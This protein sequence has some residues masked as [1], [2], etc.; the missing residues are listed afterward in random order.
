MATRKFDR[1]ME[2]L[3][4]L[5][6][7]APDADSLR[8]YLRHK[9]NFLV[10]KAAKIAA[11]QGLNSLIPDMLQA[12]PRFVAD[13]AKSDPQ[14]WAKLALVNALAELGHDDSV[15]YL[16]GLAHI[17]MEPVWGGQADSAGGLRA[18]CAQALVNCRS[19]GD[20][21]VLTY[22]TDALADADKGVRVSAA[23]AIGRIPRPE[24]APPL[25]LKALMG[26]EEPEVTG[27]CFSSLLQ[28]DA[29]AGVEFV[30]RFLKGGGDAAA[31]AAMAL[32]ESKSEAA[33][34]ALL[35]HFPAERDA[36]LKETIITAAAL[37]KQNEAFVFLTELIENDSVFSGAAVKV[38]AALGIPAEVRGRLEL[39]AAR[40]GNARL[41]QAL[42]ATRR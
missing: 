23:H 35:R 33:L 32:G 22:L 8:K 37:T 20:V 36:L 4:R 31:E 17:Q 40:S 9:S 39:E 14:C 21:Q 12:Y 41:K 34:Q 2:D 16:Q 1:D 19:L 11:A 24:A 26:D 18:A 42:D 10:A 13:A 5:R 7:A 27:T 25:R 28:I 38:L 6:D 3:D 30:G 15:P 29:D